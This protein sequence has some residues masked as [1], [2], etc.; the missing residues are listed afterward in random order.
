[1]YKALIFDLDG[2]AIP[3][4]PDGMPSE[5]LVEVVTELQRIMRVCA[6]TG[7]AWSNSK[8]IIRKLGLYDPCIICGGAQIIE[9]VSENTL[10]QKDMGQPQV[11]SIMKVARQF[12]YKVFF[13]DDEMAGPSKDKMIQGPER[14][15]YILSVSREDTEVI[16]KQVRKIPH[17]TAHETKSWTPGHCDIHI[18]HSEATK[19][20]AARALL[21]LLNLHKE[22]V[23]AAGDSN[24]DLPLFEIAG[25]KIAMENG[26]DEMK[27]KADLVAPDISED[28]LA[29]S[30]K[31]LLLR[32]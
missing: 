5:N 6:A 16:L 23:V 15:I 7:R 14:I 24:N 17:S 26:S 11:E 3:N 8:N 30:L 31:G 20:Y 1:M 22:E 2:T 9:P 10:W 13:S 12:P 32:H 29:T 19:N 4:K 18:T 27:A 21:K 25:Y 28:G